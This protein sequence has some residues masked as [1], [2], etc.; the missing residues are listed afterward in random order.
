VLR[1]YW[2]YCGS[3]KDDAESHAANGG[4]PCKV[5]EGSKGSTGAV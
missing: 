5:G 4:L 2:T 3:L 1:A